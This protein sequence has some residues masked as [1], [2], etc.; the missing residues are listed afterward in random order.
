[1]LLKYFNLFEKFS[2]STYF[3]FKVKNNADFNIYNFI[4]D[5]KKEL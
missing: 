3:N 1:M 4:F 2:V 5:S